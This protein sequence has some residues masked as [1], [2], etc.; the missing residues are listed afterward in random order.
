MRAIASRRPNP[1]DVAWL[2]FAVVNVAAMLLWPSWET[3]PFHL[4]WFSLTLLYGFR[5]WRLRDDR[6]CAGGRDRHRV[7]DRAATR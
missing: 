5:V 4:I 3:I 2:A 1:L 6:T 7:A